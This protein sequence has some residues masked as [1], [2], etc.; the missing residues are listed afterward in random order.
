MTS[1]SD[2]KLCV[3]LDYHCCHERLMTYLDRAKENGAPSIRRLDCFFSAGYPRDE[4]FNIQRLLVA[5]I[6]NTPTLEHVTFT[7]TSDSCTKDASIDAF[8][9]AVYLNESIRTVVLNDIYCSAV[10]AQKLFDRKIQWE[11]DSCRF[12]G[13]L[14]IPDG[15]T[16]NV[17]ELI[18]IDD[19]PSVTDF[20]LRLQ[21]WPHLRRL[22]ISG[23]QHSFHFLENVIHGAPNLQELTLRHFCFEY[24][25]ML[26]SYAMLVGKHASSSGRLLKWH[27]DSCEFQRD[28]IDM[29]EQIS[30]WEQA[31][32][33]RVTLDL[34]EVN[35]STLRTLMSEASCLGTLDVIYGV[36]DR[37]F[38][39]NP[40]LEFLPVLREPSPSAFPLTTVHLEINTIYF[41]G[42]RAVIKSIP[43]W[44]SRVTTLFLHFKIYGCENHHQICTELSR[45]V[46]NNMH[47]RSVG[48]DIYS[49][50]YKQEE[51]EKNAK[52]K[53]QGRLDRYCEGNRMLQTTL[54]E[55]DTIPLN[56][57]PYIYHSASRGGANM[58]YRHLRENIGYML[59]NWHCPPKKPE[60]YKGACLRS[61]VP[62]ATKRKHK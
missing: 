19:S 47:L 44:A 21:A 62:R 29:L 20:M 15:Y 27:L 12:D 31:K 14:S 7:N 49:L 46:R 40:V 25:A 33:M 23:R 4:A 5:V 54:K 13:H 59:K 58:L 6:Q 52:E 55:A 10:V 22:D 16:C 8:L 30:T 38:Y 11:L 9:D 1:P 45:A 57:W 32:S 3:Q 28:T 18:I 34:S 60:K 36:T 50:D 56:V 53:C 51:K 17:E 48:L 61:H 24:P 41:N 35:C 37:K 42:Y 39:K 26:Y 2:N 43:Q